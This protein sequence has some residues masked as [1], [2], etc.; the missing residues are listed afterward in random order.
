MTDRAAILAEIAALWGE[1]RRE[2]LPQPNFTIAEAAEVWGT[3]YQ[4]AMRRLRG[5]AAE[6]TLESAEVRD[7][8]R[9]KLV[10]WV[11]PGRRIG[12]EQGDGEFPRETGELEF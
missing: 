5:L 3:T 9:R 4:V 1:E 7:K 11:K 2:H 8:G 6:G 12:S 10:F